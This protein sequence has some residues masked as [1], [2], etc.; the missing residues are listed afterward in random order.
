MAS[1]DYLVRQFEEMGLFLAGLLRRILKMKEENQQEDME[2]VVREELFQELKLDVEQF[3]MLDNESFL[4]LVKTHFTS[5]DQLEKL[6]DI[7]KV[8]GED[9]DHSFTVTKAN[10]LRKSLFLFRHL[11]ESSTAFSYERRVRIL[12][13]QEILLRKG[14]LE[15]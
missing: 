1:R 13:L 12:E 4:A 10:Y 9:I 2:A 11:Q 15:G 5:E 3:V 6:A 14:L 8:L 7:L